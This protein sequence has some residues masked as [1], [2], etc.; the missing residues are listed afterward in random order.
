M[1]QKLVELVV[2]QSAELG[3]KIIALAGKALVELAEDLTEARI[4]R[5][6][7]RNDVDALLRKVKSTETKLTVL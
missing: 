7:H 6:R 5:Q 2:D 1:K 3:I 4:D